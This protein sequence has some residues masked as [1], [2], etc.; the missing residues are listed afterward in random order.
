LNSE[1]RKKWFEQDKP[2]LQKK[3]PAITL[4]YLID[5]EKVIAE[6]DACCVYLC[7]KTNRKDLLGRNPEEQVILYTAL[8]ILKDIQEGYITYAYVT[9][10]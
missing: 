10:G 2:N 9:Y 6:S 8:G 4:P 5:G 1:S 3:N 7:H